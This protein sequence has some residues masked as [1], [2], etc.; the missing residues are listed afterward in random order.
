MGLIYEKGFGV[1]K[2]IE[3][4]MLYYTKSNF[5]KESQQALERLNY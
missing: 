3:K 5:R 1:S 2:N 4:A